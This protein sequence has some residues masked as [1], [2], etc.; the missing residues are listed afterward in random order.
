LQTVFEEKKFVI[1][2][3]SSCHSVK[4]PNNQKEVII[5]LSQNISAICILW[6]LSNLFKYWFDY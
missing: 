4:T 6:T 2:S 3:L 1:Q 5:I